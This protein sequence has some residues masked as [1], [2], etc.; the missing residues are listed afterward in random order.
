MKIQSKNSGFTLIEVIIVVSILVILASFGIP[1][2]Q[3]M[4]QNSMIRT[5]SDSILTGLQIARAEAVKRN[6]NVQ[7]NFRGSNISDWTVCL[8]PAVAGDCPTTDDATTIQS[9]SNSE[10]SSANITVNAS[11]AGPYVFNGY[12]VMIS[13]AAALTIDIGNSALSGSR[14]LRVVVGA[15]GSAK[16]CDPAL[17]PSGTD[18]RKC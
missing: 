4:M 16:S 12:G 13:P 18:P 9:R 8:S 2:Y 14:D 3:Q 6:A 11:D 1:S 17:D 5:A 7:F 10:G 15:G